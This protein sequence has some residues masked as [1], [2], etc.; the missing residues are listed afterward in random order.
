[1][2]PSATLLE[3]QGPFKLM[4]VIASKIL[5]GMHFTILASGAHQITLPQPTT[6]LVHKFELFLIALTRKKFFNKPACRSLHFKK[7]TVTLVM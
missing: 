3:H 1:M 2:K 6:G 7:S 4:V 5:V